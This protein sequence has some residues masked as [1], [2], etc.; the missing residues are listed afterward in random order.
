MSHSGHFHL[1][2]TISASMK[3]ALAGPTITANVPARRT[4]CESD[5][6]GV[7]RLDIDRLLIRAMPNCT[8]PV[9]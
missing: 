1:V 9:S 2:E 4:L 5:E 8:I 3:T 6:L 7:F